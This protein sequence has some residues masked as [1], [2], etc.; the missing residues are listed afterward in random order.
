MV[1]RV[2]SLGVALGLSTLA[3]LAL[4]PLSA[5]QAA[6]TGWSAY[7]SPSKRPQFRPWRRSAE[8]TVPATR[9]RPHAAPARRTFVN[10]APRQ[11]QATVP[12]AT[13]GA[14]FTREHATVRKATPVNR[15]QDLG[16][17]FRPDPRRSPFDQ[18]SAYTGESQDAA[19]RRL[20]SQ[21]R[22]AATQR[23]STYEQL[24]AQRPRMAGTPMVHY[25]PMSPPRG[26]PGY[27][28]GW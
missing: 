25:R 11:T 15:A 1:S 26:Y 17:R 6:Y 21:F 22:P 8:R 23:K 20:H 4:S 14:R 13:S 3:S 12:R 5:A 9:W 2:I 7:A 27:W 24:Q 18:S 10:T 16:L 19:R 28:R